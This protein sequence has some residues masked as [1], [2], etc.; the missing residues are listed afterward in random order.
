M[1]NPRKSNY[2]VWHI[3]QPRRS[4]AVK[5]CPCLKWRLLGVPKCPPG[6]LRSLIARPTRRLQVNS[7]LHF[8]SGVFFHSFSRRGFN[9]RFSSTEAPCYGR[10]LR[11]RNLSAAFIDTIQCSNHRKSWTSS[12]KISSSNSTPCARSACTRITV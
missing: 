7:G 11:S 6:P 12:G 5:R 10:S 1:P 3:R 8:N 4:E 2:E 9:S